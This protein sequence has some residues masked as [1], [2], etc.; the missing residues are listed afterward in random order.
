MNFFKKNIGMYDRIL[1]LAIGLG[2]I[3]YGYFYS[4]ISILIGLFTL[5]EALASW[6]ILYQLLGINTCPL[7]K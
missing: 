3:V 1:R 6:C 4:Y 5:Y 2:L 7:K